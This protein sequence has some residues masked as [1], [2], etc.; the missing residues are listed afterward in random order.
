MKGKQV[1][2]THN[3]VAVSGLVLHQEGSALLIRVTR[4]AN[5]AVVKVGQ[6]VVVNTR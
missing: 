6:V 4:T 5:P 1:T 2:R 3:G